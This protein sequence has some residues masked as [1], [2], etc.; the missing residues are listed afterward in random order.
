MKK[1]RQQVVEATMSEGVSVIRSAARE[2]RTANA[3]GKTLRVAAYCRVSK[4]TA[5]QQSSM[6]TQRDTYD[7]LISRHPDWELVEIYADHGKTG[8][9]TARRAAFNRMLKDAAKGKIDLKWCVESKDTVFGTLFSLNQRRQFGTPIETVVAVLDSF[10][11][12]DPLSRYTFQDAERP[13]GWYIGT[14]LWKPLME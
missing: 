3:P 10:G 13:P 2:E 12:N 7:R 1:Q 5:R 8:T 4:D 9:S 6:E 11:A 14:G